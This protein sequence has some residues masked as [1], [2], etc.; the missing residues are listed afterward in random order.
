[1]NSAIPADLSPKSGDLVTARIEKLIYGG[2]G[3]AR[4]ERLPVFLPGTLPGEEAEVEITARAKD[5]AEGRVVRVLL[6]SPDRRDAPCPIYS[7]CGG[8]QLQHV[9]DERQPEYKLPTLR[10]ALTR[11][12]GLREV[13]LLPIVPSLAPFGYR[14]RVQFKV[15][16]GKIGFFKKR[17]HE[18]VE[19]EQCPLLVPVLNEALA[20][21]R[22]RLTEAGLLVSIEKIDILGSESKREVIVTLLL[23]GGKEEEIARL[24]ERLQ[25]SRPGLFAG[26][27][28]YLGK[29]RILLG[30]DH[31]FFDLNDIPFRVSERAFLQPNLGVNRRM[32][33][34]VVEA[35][36]PEPEE[37]VLELYCG[38]GNFTIPL[39]RRCKDLIAIEGNRHAVRDARENLRAAGLSNVRLIAQPVEF[40]MSR[41]ERR[42][43]IFDLVFLDP[44]RAGAGPGV[45]QRVVACRPRRIIYLSCSGPTLAR[46]LAILKRAGYRIGP[47]QPFDPLPQTGHIEALARAAIST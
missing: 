45:L 19:A 17:S 12:G 14:S 47:I 10:E 24:Y 46:D 39:A 27:S 35:A 30:R 11:I 15:A 42:R 44:P 21:L 20:V 29:K 37:R 32:I 5:Y 34:A 31:L 13:D 9:I 18:L 3:L 26:V 1:M 8:C 4:I 38:G 33:E 25:E 36:R 41:I 6:P 22:D 40:A 23:R 16:G 2:D 43:E 7:E 28:A